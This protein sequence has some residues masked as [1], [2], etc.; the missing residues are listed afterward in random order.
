MFNVS[1][2]KFVNSVKNLPLIDTAV[3]FESSMHNYLGILVC[4]TSRDSPDKVM[5]L[6]QLGTW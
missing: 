2:C 6:L 5:I 3:H 4:N 1:D